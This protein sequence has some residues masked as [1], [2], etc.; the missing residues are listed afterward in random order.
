MTILDAVTARAYPETM[1]ATAAHQASSLSSWQAAETLAEAV[2]T[3]GRLPELSSPVVLEAGEI[4]H[5][6]VQ[7]DAWRYVAIDVTYEQHRGGAFGGPLLFGL[8]SAA[9]TVANRR[10]RRE[11]EQLAAPQW[12]PLGHVPVLATSHRLLVLHEGA[13]H[14]VWYEAIRQIRPALHEGRLEMVFED[15]P[16]YSLTE[17]AVPY[18]AVVLA[19]ALAAQ[20]GPDAVVSALLP[21]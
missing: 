5:A 18:L 10:A 13:W 4:L 12:R 7:A 3:G 1:A 21:V 16:A 17:P 9:R 20:V 6:H 8:T 19:T 2:A 15:D 11:A 14:S